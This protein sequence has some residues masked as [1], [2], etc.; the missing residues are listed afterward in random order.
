MVAFRRGRLQKK[1]NPV[2]A[3]PVGTCESLCS[4]WRGKMDP[5]TLSLEP[6]FS[7]LE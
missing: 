1:L 4:S 7:P 5:H 3:S 6:A 2:R